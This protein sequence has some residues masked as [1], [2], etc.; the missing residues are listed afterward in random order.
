MNSTFNVNE[1][2]AERISSGCAKKEKQIDSINY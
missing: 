2:L 1:E